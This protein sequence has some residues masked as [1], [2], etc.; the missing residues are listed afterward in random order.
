MRSGPGWRHAD[1]VAFGVCP[2]HCR[3]GARTKGTG[4][5]YDDVAGIDHIKQVCWAGGVRMCLRVC[6][7]VCVFVCSVG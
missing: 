3:K 1:L 6:V 7:C 5:K 4:V 2:W